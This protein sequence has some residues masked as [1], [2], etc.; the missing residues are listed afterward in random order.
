MTV[1]PAKPVHSEIEGATAIFLYD[2]IA[3]KTRYGCI[4]SPDTGRPNLGV[5]IWGL[6]EEV[7]S[8]RTAYRPQSPTVDRGELGCA[9]LRRWRATDRVVS[10]TSVNFR[11]LLTER[12]PWNERENADR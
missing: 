4:G 12:L 8:R 2:Y 3:K 10:T 11:V 9:N 1:L 7:R 6:I 5:Q